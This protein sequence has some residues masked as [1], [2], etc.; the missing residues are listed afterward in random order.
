M[1]D[2]SVRVEISNC[3]KHCKEGTIWLF[4]ILPMTFRLCVTTRTIF[5]MYGG[6][7]I[8]KSSTTGLLEKPLHPYTR[9][10]LKQRPT[11]MQR[12]SSFKD[13]PAGEP[14]ASDES[15]KGCRFHPRCRKIIKGLC[16]QE[17][18]PEFWVR[19][20]AAACWL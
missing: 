6:K 10:S 7:I 8:E 15:A 12:T 20:H 3:S 4:C 1:L 19:D 18:P 5:A 2:A 9:L 11:R 13:V 17:M 16:D 14:P